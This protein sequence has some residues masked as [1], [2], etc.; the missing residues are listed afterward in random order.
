MK[1]SDTPR[2]FLIAQVSS[3]MIALDVQQIVEIISPG[4]GLG[5]DAMKRA[6]KIQIRDISYNL[7]YPAEKLFG[8]PEAI[9]PSYRVLLLG[10]QD[11]GNALAV[12]S[13]ESIIRVEPGDIQEYSGIS[14]GPAPEFVSGVIIQD[15][16]AVYILKPEKFCRPRHKRK[17]VKS[18]AR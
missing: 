10:P 1:N 11:S 14:N 5:V 16:Q 17:P 15:E 2:Q 9:P 8:L 3:R 13:V 18:R 4:A 6:N 7:V 12:D